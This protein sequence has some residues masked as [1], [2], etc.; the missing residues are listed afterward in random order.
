MKFS[1]NIG[2]GGYLAHH[3]DPGI[4]C[5]LKIKGCSHNSIYNMPKLN[6]DPSK[7]PDTII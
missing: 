5:L 2:F 4:I 1:D 7:D 6:P 3:F